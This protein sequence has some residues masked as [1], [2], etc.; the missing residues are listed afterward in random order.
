M[1]D[2][3]IET[4]LSVCDC[5]NYHKTAETLGLTQP[6][7]TQQIRFLENKYN[8]K[9]FEYKSHKLYKTDAA[10]IL[11]QYARAIRQKEAGLLEKLQP[12]KVRELRIGATKTI[13]DYFLPDYIYR[14]LCNKQ[15]A[16]NLVVDNT[17][18]LLNLLE[19]NQ[20]DFA[21]VEGFFDKSRYDS[22][23]LRR[24]PFVGICHKNHPFAGREVSIPEL[25]Q[26]TI[27]H[28]EDGSGTRAILEKELSGYNESLQRFK[29]RISISSFKLIL[30]M[31]KRGLGIS[32][33]YNILA[34]SDPDVAKFTL[35]DEHVVREFNIVYLKYSDMEENIRYFLEQEEIKQ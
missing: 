16:L 15:N 19:S 23:L 28:R 3:R 7:V 21:I 20:L 5:M 35:K 11:E 6:A 34:D 14:F 30:D 18:H 24:E 2:Y 1:L 12:E 17:S 4:F 27:I 22:M 29:R 9:L 13:G 8:C 25:L 26:E 31:V 33:V 10:V 32:F